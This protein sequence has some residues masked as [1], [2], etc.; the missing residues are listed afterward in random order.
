MFG[1]P[2]AAEKAAQRA[3]DRAWDEREA[4]TLADLE[5]VENEIRRRR[6]AEIVAWLDESRASFTH[7]RLGQAVSDAN[8]AASGDLFAPGGSAVV[9]AP[10]GAPR[11]ES[12][13]ITDLDGNSR[14]SL[15]ARGFPLV[16]DWWTGAVQ[17]GGDDWTSKV[18]LIS[19]PFR[20]Q[21]AEHHRHKAEQVARQAR[22]ALDAADNLNDSHTNAMQLARMAHTSERWHRGRARG[23]LARFK[24][25]D[26]CGEDEC[27][28]SHICGHSWR[29]RSMCG[30]YRLCWKCRDR[31][32]R[33]RKRRF[34]D[35]RLR[36]VEIARRKGLFNRSRKWGAWTEKHLTLTVPHVLADAIEGARMVAEERGERLDTAAVGARIR[37]LRDAWRW[38]TIELRKWLRLYFGRR[39]RVPYYRA[40]EW[41]PGG[42]KFGHPHFHVWMLAPFLSHERVCQWWRIALARAGLHD[43]PPRV[44]VSVRRVSSRGIE[45][46]VAK[47]NGAALKIRREGGGNDVIAYAEGW[48]IAGDAKAGADGVAP[49]I[50]PEIAAALYAALEGARMTTT[51][52]GLLL[53]SMPLPCSCCGCTS[54]PRSV[55]LVRHRRADDEPPERAAGPP[56]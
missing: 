1:A 43:V 19:A 28:V 20:A 45:H 46:E 27:E 4:S 15:D 2:T 54:V 40:F 32:A 55:R 39:V 47:G 31:A 22:E 35:A 25:V 8:T 10:K 9:S 16:P 41:T 29:V 7:N 36:Q 17:R 12:L 23:A 52:G 38:F 44:I 18:E 37:L 49:L 13:C 33:K 56:A 3:R 53:A 42:D 21:R 6:A 34:A 11:L 24:R 30:T 14:S 48:S 51:S 5:R 50:E 26:A